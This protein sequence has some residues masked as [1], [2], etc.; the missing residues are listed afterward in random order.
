[1]LDVSTGEVRIEL[2]KYATL[3]A[4]V[5]ALHALAH[6]VTSQP[7]LCLLFPE[8]CTWSVTLSG[9]TNVSLGTGE[10][11]VYVLPYD[12]AEQSVMTDFIGRYITADTVNRFTAAVHKSTEG[13]LTLERSRRGTGWYPSFVYKTSM[14]LTPNRDAIIMTNVV[15]KDTALE[16]TA[17]FVYSL[18]CSEIFQGQPIKHSSSEPCVFTVVKEYTTDHTV[19]LNTT[20]SDTRLFTILPHESNNNDLGSEY[21]YPFRGFSKFPYQ[22]REDASHIIYT[23]NGARL[24][25]YTTMKEDMTTFY[26]FPTFLHI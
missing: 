3:N 11:F 7:E 2:R 22:T 8:S 18:N 21:T 9:Q 20:S 14:K 24:D 26:S 10:A 25:P 17:P 12:E 1:M 4:G 16:K 6:A 19:I 13:V 23:F 15:E 5:S